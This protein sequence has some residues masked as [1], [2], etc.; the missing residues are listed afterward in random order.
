MKKKQ[1][2][3]TKGV[4]VVVNRAWPLNTMSGYIYTSSEEKSIVPREI[5]E[6]KKQR[7]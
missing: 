4:K 7:W 2:T 5:L 1:N 6:H 3:I